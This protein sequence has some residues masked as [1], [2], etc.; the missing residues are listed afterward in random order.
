MYSVSEI[1][2]FGPLQEYFSIFRQTRILPLS[3]AAWRSDHELFNAVLGFG[4]DLRGP[5]QMYIC[6]YRVKLDI[7]V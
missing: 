7:G 2:V 1:M 5:N 6:I 4:V 3:F